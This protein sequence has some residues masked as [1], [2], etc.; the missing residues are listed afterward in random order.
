MPSKRSY[1]HW[2]L[3]AFANNEFRITKRSSSPSPRKGGDRA[4]QKRLEAESKRLNQIIEISRALN[5]YQGQTFVEVPILPW[6]SSVGILKPLEISK[7][8]TG[9]DLGKYRRSDIEAFRDRL[10]EE[11]LARRMKEGEANGR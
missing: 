4:E 2:V 11:D 7:S 1:S 8:P 9:V 3:E 6:K 5:R 10:M